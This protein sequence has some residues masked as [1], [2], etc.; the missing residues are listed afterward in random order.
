[1]S[2]ARA[3]QAR[4]AH[5]LAGDAERLAAQHRAQRDRLVRQ[6]R[7]ED[8]AR[9]SYTALARAVGCSPELIAAIVK[10]RTRTS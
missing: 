1:M 6:L 5:R 4:E 8:P 10:G 7:A 9:W 3:V 2:D